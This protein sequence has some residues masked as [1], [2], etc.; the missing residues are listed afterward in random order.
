MAAEQVARSVAAEPAWRGRSVH[1]LGIER[2]HDQRH[3]ARE[4]VRV[5]RGIYL[6]AAGLIP[7]G[8]D[9][10]I[11]SA[12]DDDLRI[13]VGAN[14]DGGGEI[15]GGEGDGLV[16][17]DRRFGERRRRGHG[18]EGSEDSCAARRHRHLGVSRSVRPKP[19][20]FPR[21]SP[22]AC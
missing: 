10:Q 19:K 15:V 8:D 13:R 12:T 20:N 4:I 9:Q 11:T 3:D 14:R 17:H 22:A 16:D 18:Q 5:D 6:E 7:D 21:A 2:E 1:R